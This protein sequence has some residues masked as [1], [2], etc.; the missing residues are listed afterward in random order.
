MIYNTWSVTFQLTCEKLL[1][2]LLCVFILQDFPVLMFIHCLH[3]E[4]FKV[5]VN[6]TSNAF[7]VQRFVLMLLALWNWKTSQF[8]CLFCFG[9]LLGETAD[10]SLL[11]LCCWLSETANFPKVWCFCCLLSEVANFPV[12]MLLLFAYWNCKKFSQFWYICQFA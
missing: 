11:M 7:A 8:W 1:R 3:R 12:L 10:F 4:A 2:L 5:L 6:F 9:C